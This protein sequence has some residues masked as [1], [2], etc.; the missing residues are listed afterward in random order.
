MI[1]SN[2]PILYGIAAEINEYK[3]FNLLKDKTD[4]IQF[5]LLSVGLIGI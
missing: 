2:S 5:I 4:E 1:S 3:T